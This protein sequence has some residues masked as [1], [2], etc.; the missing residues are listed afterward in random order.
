MKKLLILFITTFL[1]NSCNSQSKKEKME[2]TNSNKANEDTSYTTYLPLMKKLLKDNNYN[3]PKNEEFRKRI[4]EYTGVD[5]ENSKYNDVYLKN[6][7]GFIALDNEGFID[8]YQVDRGSIDGAGDAFSDILSGGLN[9]SLNEDFI[10]YN[11]VLF[12]DDLLSIAKV[13]ADKKIIDD[14]VVYFN[15]EKNLNL[16]TTLINSIKKI[17]DHPKDFNLA[18]LWYNDKSKPEI[19]REKI[20]SDLENKNPQYIY[21]LTYFLFL[22]NKKINE[23]DEKLINK[24]LAYLINIQLKRDDEK[25]LS[26]NKG[27]QLLN[28][29]YVQNA[30]FLETLQ[31]SNYFDFKMVDKYTQ[32]YLSLKKEQTYPGYIQD[33]DGYTNLRKEKSSSSQIIEKIK[34]G[35][36]IEILDNSGD[37]WLIVTHKGNTGFVHKSKIVIQ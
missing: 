30:Q 27:Y 18:L 9:E 26:S 17:D 33:L 5:L 15:Y 6:G 28:N 31:N 7:K 14:I 12:N 8:S 25:D 4:R 21:D 20:I 36:N 13:I 29:F 34:S 1:I 35:E 11:K 24:T 23:V 16:Y 10:N 32:I 2:T 37:W 3:Y 19:I 22:N